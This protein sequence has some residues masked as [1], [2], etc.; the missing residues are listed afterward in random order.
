M[1]SSAPSPTYAHCTPHT[2]PMYAVAQRSSLRKSNH[3]NMS[4][5]EEFTHTQLS[6]M[7][8]VLRGATLRSCSEPCT[9]AACT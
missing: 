9:R 4:W 7:L 5:L 1:L 3:P 6:A 8:G 2:P